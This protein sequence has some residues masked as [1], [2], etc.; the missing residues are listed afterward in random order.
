MD[1]VPWACTTRR[2]PF[3]ALHRCSFG[4]HRD[5]SGRDDSGLDRPR[6]PSG[7]ALSGARRRRPARRRGAR[8]CQAVSGKCG[9]SC[10]R[11]GGVQGRFLPPYQGD[12]IKT[13]FEALRKRTSPDVI[14]CHWRDTHVSCLLNRI[15]PRTAV[16]SAVLSYRNCL[17]GLR[18]IRSAHDSSTGL[19]QTIECPDATSGTS[20]WKFDARRWSRGGPRAI[21]Q[22]GRQ[23]LLAMP[24]W[25]CARS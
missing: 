21:T 18:A 12:E 14:L 13:W 23:L 8:V 17:V 3:S 16:I 10:H 1:E 11:S 22:T 15:L 19:P 24:V 9:Q 7:C 20:S 4:R 5:W 2:A 6:H 25:L